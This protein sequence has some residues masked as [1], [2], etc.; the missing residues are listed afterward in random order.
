M[1]PGSKP[2]HEVVAVGGKGGVGKT[3][4][5]A[6]STKL[7]VQNAVRCLVIDADPVISLT[8]ALG[9]TPRHTIGGFRENVIEIP[10][11]KRAVRERPI[12]D[13]IRDLLQETGRGYDLLV[14]GRAEGPG[15]FCGLNDLLRYGIETVAKE[16]EVSLVDCEAGIEQVNR[17]SVHKIDKLLLVTDTSRRGLE[18]I[19]QVRA[20]AEKYTDGS[21]V[22][23]FLL[24]NRITSE[25]EKERIKGL[26]EASDPEVI[27]WL[28][29]DSN[30]REFNLAGTPLLDLPDSSPSV[31]AMRDI[32]RRIALVP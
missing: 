15:C 30:I 2:G 8:H 17:R 5:S 10:E 4:V 3:A 11:E 12:K 25:D 21:P 24:V 1:R 9:E 13:S 31:V 14:M 26:M 6:I 19:R 23:A 28:P 7:M 27:G 18:T 20:V 16:Y 22:Q 32:L 29:E